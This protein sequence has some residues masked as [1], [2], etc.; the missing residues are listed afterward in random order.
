MAHTPNIGQLILDVSEK[1][2][3]SIN[4][5]D[6]PTKSHRFPVFSPCDQSNRAPNPDCP[7]RPACCWSN[8]GLVKGQHRPTAAPCLFQSCIRQSKLNDQCDNQVRVRHADV[9]TRS[10]AIVFKSDCRRFR[11]ASHHPSPARPIA[12]P[13]DRARGLAMT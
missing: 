4:L 3:I 8:T 10:R 6:F 11:L 12:H 13:N 5:P 1:D 7:I 9:A 2:Q